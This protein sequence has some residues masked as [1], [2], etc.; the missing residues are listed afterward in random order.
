MKAMRTSRHFTLPRR[1]VTNHIVV[2][3]GCTCSQAI[4]YLQ[5]CFRVIIVTDESTTMWYSTWSYEVSMVKRKRD[6]SPVTNLSCNREDLE[7]RHDFR[8]IFF[9]SMTGVMESNFK[10]ELFDPQQ[11]TTGQ[12][13]RARKLLRPQKVHGECMLHT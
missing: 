7:T 11:N 12:R 4:G 5:A 3:L 6:N 13:Y 2:R 9:E 8:N 1:E 10:T